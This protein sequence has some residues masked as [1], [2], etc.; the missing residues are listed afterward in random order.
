MRNGSFPGL[1][2]KNNLAQLARALQINVPAGD[3]RFSYFGGDLRIA[4]Q[5]AYSTALRLDADGLAGT[6]R[7]SFGFNQTLDYAGTGV[8]NTLGS[9]TSRGAGGLPS[10]EVLLGK[11]VPAAAGPTGA[12]VPFTLRGTLDDPKFSLAGVPEF[13][14]GRSPQQQRQPEQ[15]QQPLTQDLFV[16]FRTLG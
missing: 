1:D 3:T 14:R 16:D 12:R 10:M 15:P 5:R 8:L 9:G 13:L 2:L 4:Q 11:V 7:G 6:G